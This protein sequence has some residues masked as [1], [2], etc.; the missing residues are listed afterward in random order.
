V[1]VIKRAQKHKYN[2]KEDKYTKK[3]NTKEQIKNSMAAVE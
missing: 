2:T 1:P 3:K